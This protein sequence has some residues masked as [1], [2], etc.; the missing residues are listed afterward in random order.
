[1]TRWRL[2][3]SQ[4]A[5]K[6]EMPLPTTAISIDVPYFEVL[7]AGIRVHD[8][9]GSIEMQRCIKTGD[10]IRSGTRR[11]VMDIQPRRVEH[12]AVAAA[13][14]GVLSFAFSPSSLR[15]LP[16]GLHKDGRLTMPSGQELTELLR[17]LADRGDRQ[18]FGVLFMHFAPRVKAYLLR[19]GCAP[20][21]AE[22][23]AQET[24]LNVWRHAASFDPA[25]AGVSTWIFTIARNLQIDQH[26]RRGVGED[27]G[28]PEGY[29]AAQ[30]ELPSPDEQ[31]ITL[32]R[33]QRVR[34][35]LSQLSAEQA[36][37]VQ[38][39]YFEETPH[40]RIATQLNIPLGTVKSRIR[41]AMARLRGLLDDI[42]S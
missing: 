40:S 15:A 20:M 32:E 6:P 3:S 31:A 19:A 37:I 42:E 16:A 36:T 2:D 28:E 4:P 26:R 21:A 24:L 35:A 27:G 17:A 8:G 41:L 34:S 10:P 11:T 22:E 13:L 1:V 29:E 39:S 25:R 18:A 30:S 14:T 33:E 38:L 12:N 23:L 9:F 5:D 7:M